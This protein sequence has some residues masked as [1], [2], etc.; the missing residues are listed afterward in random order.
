MRPHPHTIRIGLTCN[1]MVPGLTNR[2]TPLFY[3]GKRFLVPKLPKMTKNLRSPKTATLLDRT[4]W[5]FGIRIGTEFRFFF[6]TLEPEFGG[7]MSWLI[8]VG[9]S[10]N[11]ADPFF[12]DRN[13]ENSGPSSGSI[14]NFFSIFFN[15][16]EVSQVFFQSAARPIG[17]KK[18]GIS[19]FSDSGWPQGPV[20]GSSFTNKKP[21]K[22]C[23][24]PKVCK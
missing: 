2:V 13:L 12:S 18:N 23:T 15:R 8:M 19:V 17:H 16:L 11:S 14:R 5:P 24:F 21:L 9:L 10:S 6:R 20:L 3:C 4:L 1:T 22:K 7:H